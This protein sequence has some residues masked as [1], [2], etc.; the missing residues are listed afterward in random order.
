MKAAGVDHQPSRSARATTTIIHEPNSHRHWIEQVAERTRQHLPAI[1]VEEVSKVLQDRLR[2][3]AH[4]SIGSRGARI[5]SFDQDGRLSCD[6]FQHLVLPSDIA[7]LV[8]T[9]LDLQAAVR[10]E[11]P[12]AE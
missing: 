6:G 7:R 12:V 4:R 2:V 10:S 8:E 1:Q 11:I 5:S 3:E 9:V